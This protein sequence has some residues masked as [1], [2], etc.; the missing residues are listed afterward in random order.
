MFYFCWLILGDYSLYERM[1]DKTIDKTKNKLFKIYDNEYQSLLK[2][3]FKS[4]F[5]YFEQ[6][7]NDI[8]PN[9]VKEPYVHD[10]RLKYAKKL[11]KPNFS[12]EPGCWECDIMFINYFDPNDNITKEQ[13]YLVL[14][15][16]NTRYLI[17]EPIK[18]KSKN[19][20]R[21]AILNCIE[22]TFEFE[23]FIKVIKCDGES[24]LQ[25]FENENLIFICL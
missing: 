21:I 23:S 12:N 19:D 24:G 7:I 13:A 1:T 11:S 20:L 8:N 15:N 4:K 18:N 5:K 14:I 10:F 16:V 25:A 22:K 3:P 9:I 6:Y 2:Y 17:V